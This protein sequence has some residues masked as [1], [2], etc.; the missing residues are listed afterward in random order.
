MIARAGRL[1][2]WLARRLVTCAPVPGRRATASRQRAAPTGLLP[3][4]GPWLPAASRPVADQHP[5]LDQLGWHGAEYAAVHGRGRLI[6]GYQPPAAWVAL[7]RALD[8]Q[9]IRLPRLYRNDDL[10]GPDPHWPAGPASA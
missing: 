5:A 6:V 3:A 9:Q 1:P 8:E 4:D 7:R 2:H 10:A